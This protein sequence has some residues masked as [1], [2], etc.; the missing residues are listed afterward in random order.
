MFARGSS[1]TTLCILAVGAALG[2]VN[3]LRPLHID[4]TVY[5]EI[6]RQIVREPFNPYGSKLN[7]I[8]VPES[9]FGFSTNPPLFSYYLA[10]IIALFGE[11]ELMLHL[12]MIPW[13]LLAAWSLSA[14][15][16]RYT[17]VSWPV[18][19]MVLL[20]PVFLVGMNLMLDVPMLACVTGAFEC[21]CRF[22]DHKRAVWLAPAALLATCGIM[23][24]SPAAAFAAVSLV[25]AWRWRQ[26]AVLAVA[27]VPIGVF[28]IWQVYCRIVYGEF[29]VTQA[30]K[31]VEGAVWYTDRLNLIAESIVAMFIILATTFP[32]W[33]YLAPVGRGHWRAA[34]LALAVFGIAL[35]MMDEPLRT[36]P[37]TAGASLAAVFLGAWS[38]FAA[39]GNG[40]G[41]ACDVNPLEESRNDDI[42]L[43]AWLFGFAGFVVVFSPFVAPRS[44]LP[45]QPPLALLL[46]RD[47]ASPARR[48]A[49]GATIA[50]AATLTALLAWTDF[51]WASCYPRFVDHLTKNYAAHGRLVY[52][53]G[54][55]GWQYYAMKAGFVTWDARWM[56][57][58][59]GSVLA[60]PVGIYKQG[61]KAH[62]FPRLVELERLTVPPHP[63]RLS[64]WNNRWGLYFHLGGIDRLPWGFS[65]DP[66]EELIIYEVRPA[67]DTPAAPYN[68]SRGPT[69][70]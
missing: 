31:V 43:L 14:L 6:A 4:D 38:V 35:W 15:G 33:L 28:L 65:N 68:D 11:S 21:Q 41:K 57:A 34:M 52:A 60:S 67:T 23:I 16:R 8:H 56:D 25:A 61:L 58:P 46:F 69:G 62:L 1:R 54:H 5:V 2:L 53:M 12:G 55:Y 7:W 24:K 45:V 32:M 40:P 49:A 47:V 66:T 39:V 9:T 26:L 50:A 42:V 51:R 64:V 63:L 19:L 30:G 18:A 20:S 70:T 22:R 48:R 37:I 44:F 13:C 27:I 59:S 17:G 36:R 29:Q 10:L 3:T